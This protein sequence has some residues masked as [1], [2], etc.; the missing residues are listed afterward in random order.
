MLSNS[1][2][3]PKF[4]LVFERFFILNFKPKVS[5]NFQV[6]ANFAKN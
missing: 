2:V 1:F 3:I 6:F 5:G 4:I